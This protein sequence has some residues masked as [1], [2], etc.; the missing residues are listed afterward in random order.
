[1][2]A[3]CLKIGGR[4]TTPGRPRAC[5]KRQSESVF[6]CVLRKKTEKCLLEYTVGQTSRR[7][8]YQ[9][10][11]LCS[12][13]SLFLY[14]SPGAVSAIYLHIIEFLIN[15]TDE[16]GDKWENPFLRMPCNTTL[17]KPFPS[18]SQAL[19]GLW[20]SSMWQQVNKYINVAHS[21]NI[22]ALYIFR[23][24]YNFSFCD[25]K[26]CALLLDSTLK[27][28]FLWQFSSKSQMSLTEDAGEKNIKRFPFVSIH[29]CASKFSRDVCKTKRR[30]ELDP[31]ACN[32][33][34]PDFKIR[35]I[36]ASL[37]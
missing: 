21:D 20:F 34:K 31:R 15:V 18:N 16:K 33:L 3:G 32:A 7:G 30:N 5:S 14:R 23:V 19:D 4:Q 27:T 28:N 29:L 24:F 25:K 8:D 36:R 11:T 10:I 9:N 6:S 37:C 22:L 2:G 35:S 1:M 13:V 17:W 26:K 12:L